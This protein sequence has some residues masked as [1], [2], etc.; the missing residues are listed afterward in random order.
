MSPQKCEIRSFLLR[1]AERKGILVQE[2]ISESEPHKAFY[3]HVQVSKL[4]PRKTATSVSF[5]SAD[6]A[7]VM[8][9]LSLGNPE[10]D[11]LD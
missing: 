10:L 8:A 6:N 7:L 5:E 3:C 11:F 9:F 4:D 2:F 1:Y